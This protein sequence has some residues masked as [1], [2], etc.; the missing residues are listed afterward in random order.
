M[1]SRETAEG[2]ILVI[3]GRDG[4]DISVPAHAFEHIPGARDCRARRGRYPPVRDVSSF[5]ACALPGATLPD[6]SVTRTVREL[7][8]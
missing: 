2:P 7:A 8:P 6:L 5:S 1:A 3:A 4:C